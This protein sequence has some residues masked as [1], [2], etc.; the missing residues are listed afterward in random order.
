MVA[1]KKQLVSSRTI[2]SGGGNPC[3]FITIHETG[4]EDKG[5][6]AQTHANLQSNGYSASW[7]YQVDDKEI[8]QSYPDSVRCW[9]A[10]DGGGKGNM[11]SIGIE[12]CVNPDSDFKKAVANAAELVKHLMKKHNIPLTNVVQHNRWSGK[13]CPTNLRNG[14]KGINWLGFMKLIELK[15]PVEN[16][17]VGVTPPKTET[18][19]VQN[20]PSAGKPSTPN[21]GHSIVDWMNNNKMDSNYANR[22]KLAKK[23]DIENYS[24]SADQ[25]TELLNIL[26]GGG[27]VNK[28][29]DKPVTNP[30]VVKTGSIVDY[31]NSK[32]M[33]SGFA[34]R[35]KLASQYGIKNYT[36]TATQNKTLLNKLQS[37][38]S[39]VAKPKA[40]KVG[41]RVKLKSSASKYATGQR[42]P[43]SIKNKTYT[44]QQ[45]KSD[46]VLLKEI[47]SWVK[48][49]DV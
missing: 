38:T 23:Y 41:Q 48:T 15:Q 2:T 39:Q 4:N 40:F 29:V 6:G 12:I 42:I 47:Y 44:I 24:G 19:P 1:I 5:A 11:E 26:K 36:G 32:G 35:K 31:M 30:V 10:G 14:S 7:Q 37:G 20:K 49:S 22:A 9:H 45:V 25:N 33:N 21:K 27:V 34:N 16:K 8:I 13:N 3:N 43:V 18:G 17:P 28:P 46:R